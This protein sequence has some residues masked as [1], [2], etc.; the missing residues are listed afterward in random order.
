MEGEKNAGIQFFEGIKAGFPSPAQD[1]FE[2]GIDLNRVL[3]KN[4]S[5]TFMARVSGD[6]MQDAGIRDGDILIIDKSIEPRNGAIAVCYVDGEF[7]LKT[8]KKDGDIIWLVP[9]NVNYKPLKVTAKNDF[10]IWGMVTYTIAK[11]F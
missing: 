4:P 2:S 8:I 7:T 1:C 6:S 3:V 5:S 10:M 11:R 9:A